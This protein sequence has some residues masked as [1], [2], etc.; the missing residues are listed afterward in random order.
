MSNT[1]TSPTHRARI[2]GGLLTVHSHEPPPLVEVT[3]KDGK[4]DE[5]TATPGDGTSL[6]ELAAA[7]AAMPV[8][9][10]TADA[11]DPGWYHCDIEAG[12]SRWHGVKPEAELRAALAHC[13]FEEHE[14][15]AMIGACEDA[16]W[17]HCPRQR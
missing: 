6:G 3:W 2:Q 8:F 17:T 16:P 7:V 9:M 12:F 1:Y 13:D 14:I 10:A 15:E 4:R 5:K 11:D